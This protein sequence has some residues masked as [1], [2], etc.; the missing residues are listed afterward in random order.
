MT[1]EW[2]KQ[3]KIR[4]HKKRAFLVAYAECGNISQAARESG[5]I[6]NNH[7]L[8]I[9]DD[10]SYARAF[11]EATDIAGDH[12]ESEARRRAIEGV[13]K[14]IFQGG[15]QVGEQLEYSDTLLIFLMKG[16]RPEKYRERHDHSHSGS[17]PFEV[18]VNWTD[19][20]GDSTT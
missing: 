13:R 20:A 16:A 1:A 15:K 9:Q 19:D 5:V 11:A 8:W 14:P 12:L 10:E 7:Y 2:L 18:V 6:R 4:Q 17:S 3:Y